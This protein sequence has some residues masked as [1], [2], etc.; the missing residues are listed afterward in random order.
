M[1]GPGPLLKEEWIAEIPVVFEEIFENFDF[2]VAI[3]FFG[4]AVGRSGPIVCSL[5]PIISEAIVGFELAEEEEM[6]DEDA[7]ENCF[8]FGGFFS[9]D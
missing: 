3:S 2:P 5:A 8:S 9:A 1:L 6:A 7:F 4:W